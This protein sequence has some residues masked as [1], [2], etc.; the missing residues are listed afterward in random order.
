MNKGF[1]LIELMIVLVI[2]G[3]LAIISVPLY[4]NYSTKA[5]LSEMIIMATIA[6]NAVSEYFITHSTLPNNNDEAGLDSAQ[7]IN[8]KY[9]ASV[10]I[11]ESGIII[12]SSNNTKD[13]P[14][15]AQNKTVILSPTINNNSLN[16][17]CVAGTIP[18]KYLTSSCR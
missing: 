2:I 12:V 6:K 13:L 4:L 5:K 14:I 17:N 8:S 16:W 11:S 3:I 15:D 9:V 1:S 10:T 7:A 18:H